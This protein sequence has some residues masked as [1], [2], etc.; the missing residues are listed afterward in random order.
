MRNRLRFFVSERALTDC[1]REHQ[2]RHM[3]PSEYVAHTERCDAIAKEMRRLNR[4]QFAAFQLQ[5]SNT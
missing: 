2:C 5:E 4:A 3:T 1:A